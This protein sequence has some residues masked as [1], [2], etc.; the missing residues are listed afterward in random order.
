LVRSD[1]ES[2]SLVVTDD[3]VGFDIHS[4]RRGIGISNMINRVE[5]YDGEMHVESRPGHGCRVEIRLP[6]AAH[7]NKFI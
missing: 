5:S 2:I 4:E 1:E 6:I 3:G 7:S